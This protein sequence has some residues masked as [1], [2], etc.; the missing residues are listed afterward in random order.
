MN[1]TLTRHTCRAFVFISPSSMDFIKIKHAKKYRVHT[2]TQ[3]VNIV[4]VQ[5]YK[6]EV[7]TELCFLQP[8]GNFDFVCKTWFWVNSNKKHFE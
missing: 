7:L 8:Q 6:D 1:R 2:C 3:K 5:S 4:Y